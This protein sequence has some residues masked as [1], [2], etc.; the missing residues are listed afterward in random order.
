MNYWG[1]NL[2]NDVENLYTDKDKTLLR[3]IKEDLNKWKIY[4]W[5]R[6]LNIVKMSI[7]PL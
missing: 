6:R 7:L 5:I 2:T 4:S 3:E 1:I